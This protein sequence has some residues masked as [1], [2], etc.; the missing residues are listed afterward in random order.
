MYWTIFPT[1]KT[2]KTPVAFSHPLLLADTI[3]HSALQN[4]GVIITKNTPI[5]L[6]AFHICIQHVYRRGL[7][8]IFL[9]IC[10]I[11]MPFRTWVATF[12]SRFLNWWY[13]VPH[14]TGSL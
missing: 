9:A 4:R 7:F 13:S 3:T 6:Y 2:D 1:A 12:T 8:Y 14:W 11:A 10:E 5:I